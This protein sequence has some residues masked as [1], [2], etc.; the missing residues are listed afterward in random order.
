MKDIICV[1]GS[2]TSFRRPEK[3]RFKDA[4]CPIGTHP[5]ANIGSY[6]EAI[7]RNFGNKVYNLGVAGNSVQACVLSVISLATEFINKG[8][9]NFSIIFNCS[10]FYRQS[11]YFSDKMLKI[12]NITNIDNNPV[13][14]NYLFENDKSG[15]F[16]LGG[17]QNISKTAFDDENLYKVAKAYSDHIFSF[18]ECEIKALTHLLLFQNF[19]KANNIP[20]KIFFDFDNFS[21]PDMNWFEIDR[22]NEETFFKSYFVDK[23]L[24]KKEPLGYIKKDPYVYDLFKMLDLTKCWFYETDE[25]KYGGVHE[26]IFKN[27]EYKEGEDEYIAFHFEDTEKTPYQLKDKTTLLTI[28]SA[29]EKMKKGVFFETAH[30]TYYYWE[31][32]VKDVMIHWDL[33]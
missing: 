9:T 23:K 7:H 14:N 16:L 3:E 26:W 18:E 27:N 5:D 17:V 19:C 22:T 4:Y 21:L 8:N 1:G 33:F 32:F 11:L 25:I 31:K 12:K 2:N 15:F 28:Q 20:Y 6:P 24:T 13:I 29:K 10:E 30:P